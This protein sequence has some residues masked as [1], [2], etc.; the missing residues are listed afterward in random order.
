[1]PECVESG[2]K[3]VGKGDPVAMGAKD[4]D[5]ESLH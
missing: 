4:R 2:G 1:M 3:I 5:S